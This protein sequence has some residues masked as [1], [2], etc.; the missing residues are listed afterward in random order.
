MSYATYTAVREPEGQ[1]FGLL[2]GQIKTP[3]MSRESRV[4]AG[5][6]LRLLQRGHKL[7]MPHS[8]PMPSVGGRCHELR[9]IDATVTWRIV[10]RIDIDAIVIAEVFAK[11]TRTTPQTFIEKCRKRLKDYDDASQQ[12]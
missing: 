7:S 4:E 9:V 12:A 6:L 2:H 11:K 3:P 8:R 5:Y 10:Y 1:A